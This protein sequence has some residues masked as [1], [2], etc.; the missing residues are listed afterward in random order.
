MIVALGAPIVAGSPLEAALTKFFHSKSHA[1]TVR[2]NLMLIK[3][4]IAVVA[5]TEISATLRPAYVDLVRR[6][7]DA[8][9]L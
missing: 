3:A 9:S 7:R 2:A 8:E 4:Q 5:P 1:A 6:V